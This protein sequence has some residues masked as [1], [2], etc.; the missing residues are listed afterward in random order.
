[1]DAI[2]R[3]RTSAP[4]AWRQ[5]IDNPWALLLVLFFVTAALGLPLLWMSHGFTKAGKIFWSI[6]L[7][8]WTTLVFWAFWLIMG[9]CFAR[10]SGALT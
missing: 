6:A 3:P 1:M 10:I 9:W 8:I 4:P 7:I 2:N 5:A